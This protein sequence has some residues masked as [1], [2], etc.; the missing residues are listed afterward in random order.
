VIHVGQPALDV[1]GAVVAIDLAGN[2]SGAAGYQTTTPSLDE[3]AGCSTTRGG[4][5]SV[6]LVWLAVA[7][8]LRAM[9]RR[10]VGG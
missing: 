2:R 8:V 5:T 10:F 4:D 9:G 7:M 1:V 3:A 6:M